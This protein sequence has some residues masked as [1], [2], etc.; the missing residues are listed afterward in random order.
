[1]PLMS[2]NKRVVEHREHERQGDLKGS[3]M[4]RSCWPDVS[5]HLEPCVTGTLHIVYHAPEDL[6]SD[7]DRDD[8]AEESDPQSAQIYR[9][10]AS[11]VGSSC[12]YRKAIVRFVLMSSHLFKRY[13]AVLV[14]GIAGLRTS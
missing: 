11:G 2:A 8:K 5:A 1:M 6:D 10:A 9:M 13:G 7:A 14:I 3:A 12:R 4:R